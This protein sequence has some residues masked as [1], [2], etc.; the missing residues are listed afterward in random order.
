M[1]AATA[2]RMKSSRAR[3]RSGVGAALDPLER[4][5]LH[6]RDHHHGEDAC[7]GLC[8]SVAGL[9]QQTNEH[10]APLLVHLGDSPADL[11]FDHRHRGKV[12]IETG[13]PLVVVE[14]LLDTGIHAADDSLDRRRPVDRIQHRVGD[15]LGDRSAGGLHETLLRAVVVGDQGLRLARPRSHLR[16]RQAGVAVRLQHLDRGLQD[17]LSCAGR[18]PAPAHSR[19]RSGGGLR[20]RRWCHAVASIAGSRP[21]AAS[22]FESDFAAYSKISDEW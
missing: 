20:G 15:H 5:A 6:S 21:I 1:D 7:P 19:C 13:D 16:H 14:D 22:F 10:L 18:G 12:E 2:L 11:R 3:F 17:A 4:H 9:G 8:Q